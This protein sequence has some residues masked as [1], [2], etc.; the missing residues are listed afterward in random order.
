MS[1]LPHYLVRYG[2]AGFLGC[3]QVA[4]PSRSPEL[5]HLERGTRVLVR[6]E[7]GLEIGEVLRPMDRDFPLPAVPIVPGELVRRADA[8]DAERLA[9]RTAAGQEVLVEAETLAA[10]LHLPL[11]I[12]DVEGL[13]EPHAYVLHLLRYAEVDLQP[14]V[15]ALSARLTVPVHVHDLTA[16][17][18]LAAEAEENGG[19]CG[20]CGSGCGTCGTGDACGT[21]GCASGCG[22]ESPQEF[23]AQWHGYFAEL[24][25]RLER[26]IALPAV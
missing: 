5:Q 9:A 22:T 15:A 10:E 21:G 19:S 8:A 24:R 6:S 3:F 14:L 23:E 16:A 12:L 17:Q 7:R 18:A 2:V 1:H 20:S 4:D 11:S 26:R 25:Q 13:L